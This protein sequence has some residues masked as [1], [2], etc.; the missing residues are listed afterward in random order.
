[1][2]RTRK[3]RHLMLGVSLIGAAILFPAG[4]HVS[5]K[6]PDHAFSSEK[7]SDFP[8][9]HRLRTGSEHDAAWQRTGNPYV[10]EAQIADGGALLYYGAR[11]SSDAADPQIAD[12]RKR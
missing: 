1:M 9:P 12:I 10:L 11:H 4:C 7:A 3:R 2:S 5:S 6:A 8:L